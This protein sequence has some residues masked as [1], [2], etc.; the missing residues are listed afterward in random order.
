MRL[1]FVCCVWVGFRVSGW[2][3]WCVGGLAGVGGGGIAGLG[4]AH[5]LSG[6][7]HEYKTRLDRM[8]D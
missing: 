6:A 2:L 3:G 8:V 5:N 7:V 4:R 1:L